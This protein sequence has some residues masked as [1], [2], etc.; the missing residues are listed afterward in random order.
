M[1]ASAW[2]S[3]RNVV[4]SIATA[5]TVLL[6][7]DTA[8]ADTP[9]VVLV[10]HTYGHEAAFRAAFDAGLEK[11]IRSAAAGTVDLYIETLEQYRFPGMDA[12]VMRD[13]LRAKYARKKIDVVVAVLDP[14]Q[15]FL[16]KHRDALFTDVP[17]VSFLMKR[18]VTNP[19]AAMTSVW[20]GYQFREVTEL[21]LHLHPDRRRIVVIDGA[22]GNPGDVQQ[23]VESQLKGL[24]PKA[25]LTYLRD[26]PLNDVLARVKNLGSDAIVL[27]IRQF[28]RTPQ[29]SMDQ[30]EALVEIARVSPAPIYGVSEALIGHGIVGGYLAS[31]A[32]DGTLVA[33]MALEVAHGQPAERVVA[34][35]GVSLPMFDWR[36]VERWKL[37]ERQLPAGSAFVMRPTRFWDQYKSYII[38]AVSLTFAQTMLIGALLV[39]R[40]SR[41][42]AERGL[43]ESEAALRHSYEKTQDLAGRLIAAQEDERRR[44]AR[45]L[46]DELG[47]KL[48]LLSIDIE[49]L[50]RGGGSLPAVGCDRVRAVSQRAGELA[51]DVQRLSYELHPSKLEALGLVASAQAF[52]RDISRQYG[53]HVEFRHTDVPKDVPSDVGLCLFRIMQEALHNVVKHSGAPVASVRLTATPGV[54]HLH[55]ADRGKGFQV[56]PRQDAGKGST[57]HLGLVSMRERVLFVGG[58]IAIRSAPGRGVRIAV[59]VPVSNL[60]TMPDEAPFDVLASAAEVP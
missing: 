60:Y 17:I 15:E 7:H 50:T 46:H 49:L 55:I 38:G 43:R 8:S 4:L 28:I 22:L 14:A 20:V 39:Q 36:E 3:S 13:Y 58:T 1:T 40:A 37:D 47:Q 59:H 45:D 27:F 30:L 23:E 35:P 10:L 24:E 9:R 54:L 34:R 18:P 52:C 31:P 5:L 56:S 33:Q 48:A 19:G 2:R 41:R 44:I 11:A 26:L 57:G 6:G 42:R 12:V 25:S 29:Q 16:L 53:T 21:A 32:P 51:G